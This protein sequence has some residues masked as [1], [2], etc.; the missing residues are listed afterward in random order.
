MTANEKPE[1]PKGGGKF[2]KKERGK[3]ATERPKQGKPKIGQRRAEKG[4]RGTI[5]P[6]RSWSVQKNMDL[7]MPKGGGGNGKGRQGSTRY[8]MDRRAPGGK[9][10]SGVVQKAKNSLT[11]GEQ[12]RK[13]K[14]TVNPGGKILKKARMSKNRDLRTK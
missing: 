9:E 5:F 7:L 12:K 8:L 1:K 13:E 11:K 2:F 10:K 4:L 3:N 6:L 14:K